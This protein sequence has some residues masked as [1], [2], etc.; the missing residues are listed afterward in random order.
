MLKSTILWS[1]TLWLTFYRPVSDR[2]ILIDSVSHFLF[3]FILSSIII[4]IKHI[5]FCQAVLKST[6]L[7]SFTLWL[8]FYKP[9]CDREILINSESYFLF[10]SL[11]SSELNGLSN[12]LEELILSHNSLV[13]ICTRCFADFRRL[14]RLDLSHNRILTLAPDAFVNS[15]KISLLSLAGE[16]WIYCHIV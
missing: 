11:Y 6:I 2:E 15:P 4:Y 14:K 1:F 10:F 7:W 13:D 9:V 5:I 16:Q 8:V 12:S 3:C